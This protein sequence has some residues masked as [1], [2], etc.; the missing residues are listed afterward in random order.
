MIEYRLRFGDPESRVL[1]ETAR[2]HRH[3]RLT[4]DEDRRLS[5]AERFDVGSVLERRVKYEYK[6]IDP[7]ASLLQDQGQ[8][9]VV[10]KTFY[11]A[12][13]AYFGGVIAFLTPPI[14][15]VRVDNDEQRQ[16][17]ISSFG[18]IFNHG[19]PVLD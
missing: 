7:P 16:K 6:T 11:D 4:F 1:E 15:I 17:I 8:I 5:V 14:M 3:H 18:T 12:N 10:I 9:A 19:K 13:G 2:G